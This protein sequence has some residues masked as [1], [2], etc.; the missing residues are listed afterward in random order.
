MDAGCGAGVADGGVVEF[1]EA[2]GVGA[3][4]GAGVGVFGS[5][6]ASADAALVAVAFKTVSGPGNVGGAGAGAAGAIAE[7]VAGAGTVAELV[8]V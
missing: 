2:A 5:T 1:G 8:F 6:G 3:V 7:A 4:D